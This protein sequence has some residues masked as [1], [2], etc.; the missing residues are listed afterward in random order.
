MVRKWSIALFAGAGALA[1]GGAF[2]YGWSVPAG[3]A[4]HVLAAVALFLGFRVRRSG[5]GLVDMAGSL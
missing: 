5:Q 4:V 2:L 1:L 3:V